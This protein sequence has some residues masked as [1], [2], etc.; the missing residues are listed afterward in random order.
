MTAESLR[1]VVG[2]GADNDSFLDSDWSKS[3]IY[4]GRLN[5]N[6]TRQ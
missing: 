6:Y 1:I 5:L 2:C 3:S 4:F